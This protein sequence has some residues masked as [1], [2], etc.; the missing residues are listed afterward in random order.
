MRVIRNFDEIMS[1]D[2]NLI[3]LILEVC[4]WLTPDW[5]P[6]ETGIVYILQDSDQYH[7]WILTQ[8]HFDGKHCRDR[9][10]LKMAT[11][12]LWKP[13]ANFNETLGYWHVVAI[14]DEDYEGNFFLSAG[15]V[16]SIAGLEEIFQEIR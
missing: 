15:Y 9:I 3:N 16:Q 1:L 12:D 11:R 6:H 13:P 8:P 10:S 4:P 5:K 2:A 7:N 14:F